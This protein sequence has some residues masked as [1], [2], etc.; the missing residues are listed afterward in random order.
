MNLKFNKAQ[1]NR[2]NTNNPSSNP[3]M[4]TDTNNPPAE[5]QQLPP[6][7]KNE[8]NSPEYRAIVEDNRELLLGAKW[9][10]CVDAITPE[11]IIRLTMWRGVSAG[12]W[13]KL[14]EDGL[15][16]LYA[17]RIAFPIYN[18]VVT[19]V[20]G[21]HHRPLGGD[22]TWAVH[23]FGAEGKLSPLTVNSPESKT[24]IVTFESQW[25][26]ISFLD[27][28]DWH[29]GGYFDY[30][31]IA[32]RGAMNGRKVGAYCNPD[33]I[34][35]AV[36][37]NDDAAKKWLNL[38]VN[39]VN[40]EVRK[41][42]IPNE[43]KDLNDWKR[44]GAQFGDLMN[45]VEIAKVVRE[46]IS[47]TGNSAATREITQATEGE[48]EDEEVYPG[49]KLLTSA[50]DG[51]IMIHLPADDRLLS[52]FA[53]DLGRALSGATIFNRRGVTF[54]IDEGNQGLSLVASDAFRTLA[55]NWVVCY[56]VIEAK[57]AP[58][59]RVTRSMTN[60]DAGAVLSATGFLQQLRQLDRV[61]NVRLPVMR[62]NGTIELLPAGYDGESKTYTFAAPETEADIPM[63]LKEAKATINA[64]FAE[65]CFPEDNGRS[66]AV[67]IA[68]MMTMFAYGLLPK[69]SIPPCFIVT[70]NA[71]GAGKSL[72]V[73]VIISSVLGRFTAGVKPNNDDEVRKFLTAAVMEGR[74]YVVY[75]NVKDNLNS[76]ALEAFL[77]TPEWSDRILGSSKNFTAE[78]FTVVFITGNN[79]AISPDMRRRSLVVD[80]FMK[81]ERAE[82]RKFNRELES[83]VKE[84]RGNIYT[85]LWTLVQNW[86]KAGQPPSKL[87]NSS[88][89]EWSRII[90]GIVEYAGYVSP[91]TPS[92][93][94]ADM[95]REGNNMRLMAAGLL[96]DTQLK[97]FSFSE[98]VEHARSVGA[99][100]DLLGLDEPASAS[101]ERKVQTTISRA[102][103]RYNG[104]TVGNY[105]FHVLGVGHS[106][107]YE[108]RRIGVGRD[109]MPLELVDI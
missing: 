40:C 109:G 36:M 62:K 32:T 11:A 43:F 96:P 54:T 53:G 59:A 64:L 26:L 69:G 45:A 98:L 15:V 100:E 23:W 33:T 78:K 20:V 105:N 4:N 1:E 74:L 25:D 18:N 83:Y 68:G 88:F 51:R 41:V 87:I 72:L 97:S 92:E 73:K 24:K 16:G 106:R 28:G 21:V 31:F 17:G 89:Q 107:R 77:T 22:G 94:L 86:D 9:L 44:A 2:P 48:N 49:V 84:N 12:T 57:D 38:I 19:E 95:D 42:E 66:L 90:G 65:F 67:A 76:P 60:S 27:M 8:S 14:K 70:A 81:D 101:Y 7:H 30:G 91:L 75:D 80:L 79:C 34:V 3:D 29:E 13:Q 39:S 99:F 93:S 104:R 71:E 37:Q 82:T 63:T 55:E 85:A 102:L 50:K 35:Y 108:F 5:K 47:P 10:P 61:N 52:N 6:K 56:K 58:P 46:N 103:K